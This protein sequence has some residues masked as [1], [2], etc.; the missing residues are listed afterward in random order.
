MPYSEKE[1]VIQLVKSWLNRSGLSIEQVVARLQVEGWDISRATFENHF[2]TRRDRDLNVPPDLIVALVNTFTT[3]LYPSE[4]CP[5]AEALEFAVLTR[6]PLDRF[7]ELARHFPPLEFAGAYQPYAPALHAE[8]CGYGKLRCAPLP[9]PLTNFIGRLS[10]MATVQHRLIQGRWLT[11]TGPGGC[12]KTR[13]AL[14]IAAHLREHFSDGIV[15]VPLATLSDPTLVPSTLARALAL[16]ECAG[17]SLL[18]RMAEWLAAQH[19][20]IILDNFEHLMPA[21]AFVAALVQ[22][23]ATPKIL[24]TSRAALNLGGEQE[25]NVPPLPLPP[26]TPLPPLDTLAH[27]AAVELFVARAQ[28]VAPDFQLT[29]RNGAAV[30]ELCVRL[31][32]LP[33]AIEL[34]AA[35]SKLL[36]P[37]E[38]LTRLRQRWTWLTHPR[39]DVP[40]RQ[41][42]LRATLDWSYHLLTPLEQTLFARLAV[43]QGGFTITAAHEVCNLAGDLP[44]DLLD[45]LAN[46]LNQSMLQRMD[47]V[48]SISRFTLLETL[49]AYAWENLIARDEVAQ[50]QESHTHY[51]LAV[52]EQAQAE[53]RGPQQSAWLNQLE[54]EQDNLRAALEWTLQHTAPML[55]FRLCNALELFWYWCSH[56]SE[57]RRWVET[58]LTRY[59]DALPAAMQARALDIAAGFAWAQ[60]DFAAAAHFGQTSLAIF[61]RIHDLPGVVGALNS[62]GL[63]A[64]SQGQYPQAI[65]AYTESLQLS[66]ELADEAGVALLLHNLGDTLLAYGEPEQAM[67]LF[68]ESLTLYRRMNN[69]H[70]IATLLGDF[71]DVAVYQGHYN[72]AEAFYAQGLTLDWQTGGRLGIAL[73]LERFAQVAAFHAQY[74]RALQLFGA[75]EKFRQ[76]SGAPLSC[77]QKAACDRALALLHA[78]GRM[79]DYA[80]AWNVG[81]TL[82]LQ[83]AINLALIGAPLEEGA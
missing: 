40:A 33:L 48:A 47:G 2:T 9:Q 72:Q 54:Q 52:A 36:T 31:D 1:Q 50:L 20:L 39:G 78:H 65:Q 35:R 26:L 83:Q 22:K 46:L 74:T 66:R 71:G 82:S 51:Y 11:L 81:R 77:F 13:L 37:A 70:G 73:W 69:Q 56:L 55:L 44:E 34:A 57:G 21:A 29:E 62:L 12:G 10:E 38:M 3:G 64:E 19:I 53:L 58:L 16:K 75:A 5:A 30:A 32:G 14:E 67:G 63:V 68:E 79:P 42:A 61:R 41:R 76:E 28:A 43:F 15:F 45:T 17:Q 27:C 4:R 25:F 59:A 7:G 24:V 6:L 60:G 8:H 23:T 80:A 18:D 49:H